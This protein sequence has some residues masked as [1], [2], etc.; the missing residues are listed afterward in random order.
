MVLRR[1]LFLIALLLLVS[2][3]AAG[4]VDR[5]RTAQQATAPAEPSVPFTAPN[6]VEAKLPGDSEIRA[7]VGDAVSISITTPQPTDVTVDALGITASASAQV[8]GTLEFVADRAGRYPIV[9]DL[10]GAQLG[11]IVVSGAPAA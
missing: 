6:R 10:T 11:L 9:D 7:R 4:A 2:I 8:P 1:M 3:V 5:E